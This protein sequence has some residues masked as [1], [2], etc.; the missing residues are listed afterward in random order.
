MKVAV[1]C[2]IKNRAWIFPEWIDAVKI[3]FDVAGLE[4]HFALL[5]GL[6][7][8]GTDDG[9]FDMALELFATEPGVL[10]FEKEPAISDVRTPWTHDRYNAMV[11]YRNVLLNI[12]RMME[13]DY[14][15]S[16]DSDI[17]LHPAA[18]EVLIDTIKHRQWDAIGGK[19]YL[20]NHRSIVSYAFHHPSGG[21]R[22]Q[23]QDGA[24]P[25]DILMA[26]KLMSPAAYNVDY[27]FSRQG[28][29]IGWSDN[30]RKAGLTLGW[31]GRIC[32]KHVMF[33]EKLNEI[34]RRVGW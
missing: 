19:V 1:G 5:V 15:L 22:R 13:P 31:D 11:E 29:D 33:P 7:E 14:F 25:V 12:V 34:D 17:L 27:T 8:D 18:L 30:C 32:S 28:E 6:E 20:G 10:H 21:L 23:D 26:L 3:A 24:F 2:P 9:T 4:P 16:V